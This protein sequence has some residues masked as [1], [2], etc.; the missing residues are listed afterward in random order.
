MKIPDSHSDTHLPN[1][2]QFRHL[3]DVTV[4]DRN[5]V[6]IPGC[7]FFSFFIRVECRLKQAPM[8]NVDNLTLAKC[9]M[10]PTNMIGSQFNTQTQGDFLNRAYFLS[11]HLPPPF[12]IIIGVGGLPTALMSM[13]GNDHKERLT[14]MYVVARCEEKL[15]LPAPLDRREADQ[16]KATRTAEISF[17]EISGEFFLTTFLEL[18]TLRDAVWSSSP[19]D[20]GRIKQEPQCECSSLTP[21]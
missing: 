9:L 16:I 17:N 2:A 21:C 6:T 14:L 12:I 5:T 20:G 10:G 13:W 8:S 18:D 15:T 1:T 19:Y 11:S 4:I 3:G 7:G